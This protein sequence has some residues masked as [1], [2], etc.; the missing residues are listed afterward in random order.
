MP[1]YESGKAYRQALGFNNRERL[2]EYFK[3]KD[4]KSVN[5][6]LIGLLNERLIET[7]SKINSVICEDYKISNEEFA[8]FQVQMNEAYT[9]LKDYRIIEDLLTNNGRP[10]ESVYF[11]WMRGYLVALYFRKVV[12]RIFSV[13][14]N[15]IEQLGEDNLQNVKETGNCSAFKKEALADLKIESINVHIEIQAGFT[16]ENDIKKSKARDAQRRQGDGWE[17]YVLHFDLFNGNLAVVNVTNLANLPMERWIKNDQFEGVYTVKIPNEA[18]KWNLG[19][20]L[21]NLD[22]LAYTIE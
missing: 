9:I 4:I 5:W 13:Q 8:A 3:A 16:G 14:E 2:K 15:E 17:T 1:R 6:E 10:R 18:F 11:N 21:P 7:F 19:D 12:A 20:T 22:A